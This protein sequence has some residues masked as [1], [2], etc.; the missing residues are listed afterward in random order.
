MQKVRQKQN[1][2]IFYIKSTD[3]MKRRVEEHFKY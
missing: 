1:K 2:N 3:L